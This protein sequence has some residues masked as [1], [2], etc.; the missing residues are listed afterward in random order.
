MACSQLGHEGA[1]EAVPAIRRMLSHD[2][3]RVRWHACEALYRLAAVDLQVVT[4]LEALHQQP[5]GHDYSSWVLYCR[6]GEPGPVQ[7]ALQ[8][9]MTTDELLQRARECLADPDVRKAQES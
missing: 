1:R 3:W 8:Q 5:E 4:T 2:S 9:N 6:D 7:E